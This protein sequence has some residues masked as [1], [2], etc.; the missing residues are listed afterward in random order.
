MVSFDEATAFSMHLA[1]PFF[2]NRERCEIRTVLVEH[3][4]LAAL[5]EHVLTSSP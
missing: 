5:A 1:E 4:A 2:R 3:G